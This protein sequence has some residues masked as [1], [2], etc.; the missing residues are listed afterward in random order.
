MKENIQK[1]FI[2]AMKSKDKQTLEVIKLL[3]GAIQNEEIV[4]KR[5]LNDE[6]IISIVVKQVKMRKDA[7]VEFEK[8]NREDLIKSYQFEIDVLNK[9]LPKQLSI[10]EVNTILDEVFNKI[11]P[12]S[13]KDMGLIMKEVTG[14][15]K[16][17]TDME[18]VSKI[19]KDRLSNL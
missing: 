18:N 1:D 17:K 3:K 7:I 5:E 12:T 13:Q 14:K 6:E 16:G 9:Y 15:L 8:A 10:E 19:I 2:N 11:N 4:K